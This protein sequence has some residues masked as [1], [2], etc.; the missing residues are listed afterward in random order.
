MLV[1]IGPTVLSQLET[2]KVLDVIGRDNVFPAQ[3]RLGDSLTAALHAVPQRSAGPPRAG[4][5][6]RD[7]V[8][9]PDNDSGAP[10]TDEPGDLA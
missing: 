4:A 9:P 10:G 2:T 3:P 5:T 7:Y 8:N 1:G 6:D